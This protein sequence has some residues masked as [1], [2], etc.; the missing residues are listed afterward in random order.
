MKLEI[1]FDDKYYKSDEIEHGRV[2]RQFTE[3]LIK[4]IYSKSYRHY[5][6]QKKLTGAT[7]LPL[8]ESER[9]LYSIIAAAID[10]ITPVHLSEWSFN[11][12]ETG[13]DERI[14]DFWCLSQ[15]GE[16][17]KV[18][19][20]FIEVKKHGYCLSEGTKQ[21]FTQTAETNV[22]GIINQLTKLKDIRPNWEG[23]GDV[24]LGLI[25]THSYRGAEKTSGYDTNH[26]RDNIHSLLDKRRG[27]QLLH[28]TWTIPNELE[29]QWD[30]DVCESVSISAIAI[31]KQTK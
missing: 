22:K 5:E 11:S 30:S 13:V 28:S 3:N 10:E 16:N 2:I 21:S 23:D 29:I 17:G 1:S 12:S 24:F 25:I 26:V 14:V 15:R 4:R 8:L 9:N 7:F 18:V 20:Y 19:N 31:T 6:A 27:S